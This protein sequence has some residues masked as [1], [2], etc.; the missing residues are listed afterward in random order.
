MTE[1]YRTRLK[2]LVADPRF[3]SGIY[4]YCDRW[5]ERCPFTARCVNF[6]MDERRSDDDSVRDAANAEFWEQL[7]DI[8]NETMEMLKEMAAEAGVDLDALEAT[9]TTDAM[10]RE[11]QKFQRATAHPLATASEFYIGMVDRWFQAAGP[12][13]QAKEDKLNAL[14][15]L[16]LEDADPA[17][18]AHVLEDAIAVTRWYQFLIGAKLHRALHS[19]QDDPIPELAGYPRDS[20]GSAKVALIAIDRSMAAWGIFLR[21]FSQH[22]T[23]TLEILVH[24]DHLRRDAEAEFPEARA[25]V[26]PGFDEPEAWA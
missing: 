12:A 22:E 10:E 3:I 19:A 15:R 16:G 24:L 4:N 17:G 11:A 2:Q 9:D 20:D 7:S 26:R 8:L 23:E 14:A 13:F 5:C 18:E 21:A 25:F 1:T 6:A